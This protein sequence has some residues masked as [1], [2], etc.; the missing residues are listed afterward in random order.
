MTAELA[1]IP[2]ADPSL[3]DSVQRLRAMR[4]KLFD[5]TARYDA[6]KDPRAVVSYC[7]GRMQDV[8]ATHIEQQEVEFADPEWIALLAEKLHDR[9]INACLEFDLDPA[10]PRVP[11][12][13][14]AI[15]STLKGTPCT[16][17][18]ALI[19]PFAAH[20]IHDLPYALIDARFLEG[21]HQS[22]FNT[23]NRELAGEIENLVQRPTS[24]TT[25]AQPA[26]ARFTR[27]VGRIQHSAW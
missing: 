1:E 10:S 23:V 7:L 26:S 22:D 11:L 18:E 20:F 19:F 5:L 24:A 9:W 8:L 13:H 17:I 25:A 2:F 15:F 3:L 21:A 27:C 12:P 6:E 4:D 16:V 14:R